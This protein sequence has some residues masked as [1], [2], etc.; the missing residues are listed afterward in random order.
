MFH[1]TPSRNES[2][3]HGTDF[4][5]RNDASSGR[6]SM[7]N[8]WDE[9]QKSKK[10]Q[11]NRRYSEAVGR[12]PKRE[13]E[14]VFKVDEFPFWKAHLFW[15]ATSAML[16]V[17]IGRWVLWW[18]K[19]GFS[20]FH[21][22]KEISRWVVVFELFPKS[23]KDFEMWE[24]WRWS[25]WCLEVNSNQTVPERIE[26]CP[27]YLLYIGDYTTQLNIEILNDSNKPL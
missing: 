1:W 25:W 13:S 17:G 18:S 20:A 19:A 11:V 23:K 5:K 9:R 4:T 10:C 8:S 21:G 16:V 24:S 26:Q 7:Q 14:D 22:E 3:N 6:L 15:G 27:G 12:C 2:C